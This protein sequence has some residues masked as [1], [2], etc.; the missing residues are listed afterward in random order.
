MLFIS[1]LVYYPFA[2]VFFARRIL[3][4]S[5]TSCLCSL[6]NSNDYRSSNFHLFVLHNSRLKDLFLKCIL[7]DLYEY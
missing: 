1:W 5:L 6:S 3:V 2:F 4:L 7:K